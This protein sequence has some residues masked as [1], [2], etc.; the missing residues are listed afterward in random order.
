MAGGG[1]DERGRLR[2]TSF[3]CRVC[4][5]QRTQA[6]DLRVVYLDC[7][8]QLLCSPSTMASAP[9]DP[10]KEDETHITSPPDATISDLVER[11]TGVSV[12]AT[13]SGDTSTSKSERISHSPLRVYTRSQAM[14]LRDSPLVRPPKGMPSLKEWFGCVSLSSRERPQLML[15]SGIGTNNKPMQ[16]KILN[17]LRLLLMAEN[18]GKYCMITETLSTL[19]RVSSS[20]RRDAEDTGMAAFLSPIVF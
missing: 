16:R 14:Y 5:P 12:Q 4:W 6:P 3:K 2:L 19:T 17:F 10:S 8:H 13:D 11:M 9:A 18:D 20:F 1:E 15:F 7:R